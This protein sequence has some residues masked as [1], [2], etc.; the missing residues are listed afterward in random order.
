MLTREEMR[1]S[2]VKRQGEKLVRIFE[3]SSVAICGLGGLGSNIA[4]SL[5]RAGVGRLVLIDYDQVDVSNMNRQQYRVSQIGQY[6]TE[7]LKRIL[8]EIAPYCQI[9]IHTTKITAE[10]AVELLSDVD[11]VCEAFDKAENKAI[12]VNEVLEKLPDM[13]LIA[14]SGMAGMGDGNMIQTKMITEHFY[15][16]GDGISEVNENESLVAPR[17]MLCAAHEA[18]CVLRILQKK[19]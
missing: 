13:Y 16:C 7:A 10:N 11:V 15:I 6:K 19:C 1:E 18:L 5:A 17:V 2:L 14:A 12:L 4:I 9:E 3:Q 8:S